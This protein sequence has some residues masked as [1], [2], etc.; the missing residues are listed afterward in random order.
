MKSEPDPLTQ[1]GLDPDLLPR[2]VAVIMDGNGRWA[3]KR[4]M[5]RVKGHEKGSETVRDIVTICRELG[6]DF[7]TLYA[8]STENWSRPKAE[9]K[10]LMGLLK[11]FVKTKKGELL[12]KNIRLNVIGQKD[13][14]PGD[15]RE[16]VETAMAQTAVNA[17]MVLNLALSYGS[18]EEITRAAKSI[19]EQ[20]SKGNLSYEDIT[21]ELLG[22]YLYTG[23]MPDP[24]LVIRT[25]GEMRLSNFLLWQSAYAE[26]FITPTLWPDFTKQE[27]LDILKAYQLRDRRFGKVV[28]TSNDGS[29]Q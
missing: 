27:F 21:E 14:L 5:N 25:S 16:E 28:C 4:L 9:V 10:A 3:K 1:S 22:K 19:A 18:R 12:E 8:F 6:I 7:L 23:S 13:R 15:V 26:L 11:R 24:D 2:H 20:V 29:Q 17:K